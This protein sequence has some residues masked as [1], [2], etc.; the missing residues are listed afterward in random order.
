MEQKNTTIKQ[1]SSKYLGIWFSPEDFILIRKV[2]N[3][4][5][6][7]SLSEVVRVAVASLCK[8]KIKEVKK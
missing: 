6:Y 4:C 1:N 7:N 3:L 8:K 5:D 2:R